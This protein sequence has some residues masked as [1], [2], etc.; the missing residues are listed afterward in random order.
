MTK[1]R[2]ESDVLE[3]VGLHASEMEED[4]AR[5]VVHENKVLGLH[6]VPGLEVEAD[7]MDDGIRALVRVAPGAVIEKPVHMCF[8]VL[9]EEG[10]QRIIME[11]H[12]E[13]QSAVSIQAHCSFPY[14]VDVRHEMEAEITIGEGARYTY[15]ERHVHG[16]GGGVNVIPKAKVFVREGGRFQTEFELIKGRVGQMAIDYETECDA[17]AVVDMMARVRGREDDRIKIRETSRLKGKGAR[18]VLTS[19]VAL[20]DRARA[21]IENVMTAE[22]PLSR[23]H[24]DC[25]E[26]IQDEAVAR[27]VPIVEARHPKAHVTHEAA[28]G[29][30]DSKQLETLMARGMDEEKASDLIIQGLIS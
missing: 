29:S 27:A 22:A 24:V 12:I 21:D 3:T 17:D 26:I 5:V 6:L 23:G 25:K 4:V 14:A 7:E 18:G 11:T 10:L 16:L 13:E 19:Y 2:N 8:G 30:V 9:P 15:F 1:T 20:R 28:I